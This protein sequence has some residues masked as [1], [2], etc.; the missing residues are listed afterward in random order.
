MSYLGKVYADGEYIVHHGEESAYMYVVQRGE[1]EVI[2]EKSGHP[3][4]LQI[5][6]Q[7]DIFGEMVPFDKGLRAVAIRAIGEAQVL[8]V[9]RRNLLRRIED[10]PLVAMNIIDHLCEH[11]RILTQE[12]QQCRREHTKLN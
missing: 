11:I 4:R 10:D 9:D 3:Q 12:I 1:L 5:L 6:R 7:G 2:G 8:T